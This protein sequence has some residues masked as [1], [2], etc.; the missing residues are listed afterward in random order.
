MAIYQALIEAREV[1]VQQPD[2]DPLEMWEDNDAIGE[3]LA[4]PEWT[5]PG[6]AAAI[7]EFFEKLPRK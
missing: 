6:N 1:A 7:E 4:R 5:L 2:M 3:I